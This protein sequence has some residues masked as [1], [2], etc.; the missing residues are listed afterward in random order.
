[1]IDLEKVSFINSIGVREW[2][3]LLR[4]LADKKVQVTLR[5]CSEAMVYQLNMIIDTSTNAQVDSFYA[6]YAC[7]KCGYEGSMCIEM[8]PNLD[9]LRRMEAPELTCPECRSAMQLSEIPQ[10]YLLFV[11]RVVTG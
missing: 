11:E 10:R 2:I 4:Q 8:G 9:R 3:R 5:R 1:V 7:N 6:P